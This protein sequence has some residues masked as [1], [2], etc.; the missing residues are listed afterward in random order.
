MHKLAVVLVYDGRIMSRTTEKSLVSY[1][2]QTFQQRRFTIF[3]LSA[4][5]QLKKINI[6]NRGSGYLFFQY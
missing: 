5:S 4:G 1:S 3:A 2:H 6:G